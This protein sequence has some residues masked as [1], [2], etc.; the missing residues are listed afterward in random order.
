M[1]L[2]INDRI[3]FRKKALILE[4][5]WKTI[6]EVANNFD[7]KLT[8][9]RNFLAK[10]NYLGDHILK[11]G[12]KILISEQDKKFELINGRKTTL[13]SP[14]FIDYI[15]KRFEADFP[16][17][18]YLKKIGKQT[19]KSLKDP[20]LNEGQFNYRFYKFQNEIDKQV[21]KLEEQLKEKK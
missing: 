9:L 11:G 19:L 2:V 5:G 21:K 10:G 18:N 6:H 1:F 8:T 13:L 17:A 16:I 4:K 3:V 15:A 7:I 12:K 20:S 14:N